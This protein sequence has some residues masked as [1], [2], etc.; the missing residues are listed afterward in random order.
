[1][2]RVKEVNIW[3]DESKDVQVDPDPIYISAKKSE[4][5]EWQCW[6]GDFEI[7]FKEDDSPFPGNL[8]RGGQGGRIGSGPTEK[9]KVRENRGMRQ[10]STAPDP[11]P[12]AP[13]NSAPGDWVR[14][15]R[16]CLWGDLLRSPPFGRAP[17][18]HTVVYL[19]GSGPALNR[20]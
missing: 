19:P 13:I 2:P 18:P 15:F 8:Y 6:Q 5:V 10:T 12:R 4:Q 14:G 9:K 16:L 20:S 11:V 7:Q 17:G 3:V 1:M